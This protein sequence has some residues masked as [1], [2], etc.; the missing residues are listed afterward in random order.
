MC[1]PMRLSE[2]YNW[3]C[4][5]WRAENALMILFVTNHSLVFVSLSVCVFVLYLSYT[6]ASET[7]QFLAI[8]MGIFNCLCYS[9]PP[10]PLAA[11]LRSQSFLWTHTLLFATIPIPLT[12]R[13]TTLSAMLWRANWRN[14]RRWCEQRACRRSGGRWVRAPNARWRVL[15]PHSPLHSATGAKPLR[16]RRSPLCV[17][18]TAL[19]PPRRTGSLRP[20]VPRLPSEA[21]CRLCQTFCCGS[22]SA[23]IVFLGPSFAL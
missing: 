16:R 10:P 7:E 11:C 4:S 15:P 12:D 22:L 17:R 20:H 2:V 18:F 8:D 14:T 19:P 1:A 23:L 21:V 6:Q 3:V 13:L 9:P 5:K